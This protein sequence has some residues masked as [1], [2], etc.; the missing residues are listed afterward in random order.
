MLISDWISDVCSSDLGS[1]GLSTPGRASAPA[2]RRAGGVGAALRHHGVLLLFLLVRRPPLPAPPARR[3]ARVPPPGHAVL[4]VL[5][6][7]DPDATVGWPRPRCP[8]RAGAQ[9]GERPPLHRSG[10]AVPRRS[11]LP[12]GRRRAGPADLPPAAAGRSAGYRRVLARPLPL[13]R[14]EEHTSELQS[15]MRTSYAVFCLKKKN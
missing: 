6:K 5:G 7:R 4:P 10:A 12:A 9:P 13:G 15:L 14:S 11:T 1:G 2:R 3:D 8:P